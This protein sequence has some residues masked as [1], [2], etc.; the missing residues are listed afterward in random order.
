MAHHPQSPIG[1]FDSGLGGLTIVKAL[2]ELMPDEQIIYVGD[3]AH[4]PYGD[5]APERVQ[6]YSKAIS[7]FLVK[8]EVKA[9]I[10]ACNTASAVGYEHVQ[11]IAG[12]VPVFEVIGPAAREAIRASS[13]RHIGVIGTRTTIN[14]EVYQLR[15]RSLYTQVEVTAKATPLLVPMIEEGWLHNL[16]SQD[17]IDAYM[18]DTGFSTIDTLILGCTH[19]PLIKEQ[20]D[21][22]FKKNHD[23]SIFLIDSAIV[24]AESVKAFLEQKKRTAQKSEAQDIFYLTDYSIHFR[25]TAEL[26][27]GR[28]VHFEAIKLD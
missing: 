19:Y 10:I 2:K 18:S 27:L 16:V 3:T 24:V 20:I 5:K 14:S 25:E 8:Q 15:L 13:S 21:Q 1:V 12:D 26:F 6:D 22:Y 17:V 9:I 28:K 23:H 11:A 7:A 4:L